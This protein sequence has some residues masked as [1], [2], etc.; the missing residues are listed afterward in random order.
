MVFG[1]GR[2]GERERDMR[3]QLMV[4]ILLEGPSWLKGPPDKTLSVSTIE[5]SVNMARVYIFVECV[6]LIGQQKE[7]G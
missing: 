3:L 2:N 4:S 6:E 1:T 5:R 7:Y